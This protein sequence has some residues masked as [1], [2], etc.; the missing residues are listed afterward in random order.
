MA[1]SE[2][3]QADRAALQRRTIRTLF[4]SQ[5]LG[6]VGVASGFA[7]GSLLAEEVSGS[8]SLAGLAQTSTV[9]GAALVAVPMSRI[10]ARRG[11]RPGL[12]AGYALGLSGAL[13]TILAAAVENYPLLLIGLAAFG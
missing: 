9:L 12:V 4:T 5:M 8:T 11:R 7:V 6:G 1:T 10:M 2:E 13:I 3:L